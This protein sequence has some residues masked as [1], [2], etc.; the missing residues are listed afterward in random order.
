[1]QWCILALFF[2][3]EHVDPFWERVKCVVH[4]ELL[5]SHRSGV[6]LLSVLSGYVQV[7][8]DSHGYLLCGGSGAR[9]DEKSSIEGAYLFFLLNY[10]FTLHPNCSPY[11][12]SPLPRH[13]YPPP[14]APPFLLWEGEVPLGREPILPVNVSPLSHVPFMPGLHQSSRVL[15]SLF[16]TGQCIQKVPRMLHSA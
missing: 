3:E 4:K 5:K 2:G 16:L 6:H 8:S 12:S 15:A 10:L 11:P 14:P 7:T 13:T 1:M 9:W